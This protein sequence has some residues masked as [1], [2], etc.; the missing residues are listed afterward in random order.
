MI[1]LELFYKYI[2]T[3]KITFSLYLLCILLSYGLESIVL[4][5]LS[6]GLFDHLKQKTSKEYNRLI[7]YFI[8]IAVAWII[9]QTA[10]GMSGYIEA[11]IYPDFWVVLRDHIIKSILYRY[12]NDFQELELG[13]IITEL[14]TIPGNFADFIS[15]FIE[16]IL[17]RMI[18]VFVIFLYFLWINWKIGLVFGLGLISLI[19]MYNFKLNECVALS[20]DRYKYFTDINEIVQ[21]KLS[22]LS[23]IYSS[24]QV[25]YEIKDNNKL[26]EGFGKIY[27]SQMKCT[28]QFKIYS[29][30]ANTIIFIIVNSLTIY[31]YIKGELS[32]TYLVSIFITV[33]YLMNYLVRLSSNIPSFI[34]KLGII[35]RTDAFLHD[36]SI[37]QN[38][39]NNIRQ[40]N[41]QPSTTNGLKLAK[42]E[43]VMKNVSFWYTSPEQLVLKNINLHIYPNS[44]TCIIG[45]SGSGKSTLVK[46][47]LKFYEVKEGAIY[48]DGKNINDY[49]SN[50]LRKNI[51]YVNQNTK[52]FNKSIYDNILYSN[53]NITKKEIDNKIK[54]LGISNIFD[55]INHNYETL[56]GVQGS[57]LSGGQR[58]CVI[59]LR[60]LLNG[61]KIMIL[62]EPTSAIDEDNKKYIYQMIDNIGRDKTVI[63][64]THDL[65]N[66]D[67]YDNVYR[68]KD[69]QLHPFSSFNLD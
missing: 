6:A 22:N 40:L 59:I 2:R 21:D 65:S 49:D 62:D 20:N 36:I 44:K 30:I 41:Q 25:D 52:L 46:L 16:Y 39:K 45:T 1:T 63:V 38:K 35:E 58:Q 69:K 26:N 11:I 18:I 32:S 29:Y 28:N 43:I 4:P 68:M 53:P 48:I 7:Q 5:R 19:F 67:N 56:V 47:L 60:E 64:I 17:P 42:G 8:Y 61:S 24:G 14:N 27:Q 31:L 10:M 51:S 9:I 50:D 33:L 15:I 23:T 55:N 54:E 57:K 12:E 37:A 34:L 66:L 13:K 3:N